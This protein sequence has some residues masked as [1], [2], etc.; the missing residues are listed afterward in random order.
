[1]YAMV[2]MAITSVP[3]PYIVPA[4]RAFSIDINHIG[5]GC[6]PDPYNSV[7]DCE[8]V[9]PSSDGDTRTSGWL[10]VEEIP[11]TDLAD[12]NYGGSRGDG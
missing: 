8:H 6:S 2:P 12:L 9:F 4:N 3:L 5:R 10:R 11:R 1:M 7:F